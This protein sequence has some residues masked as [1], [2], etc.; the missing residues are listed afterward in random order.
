MGVIISISGRESPI[1]FSARKRKFGSF[2]SA[3][4]S[5]P[6]AFALLTTE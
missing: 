6:A 5:C 3:T 2:V 1:S 4:T